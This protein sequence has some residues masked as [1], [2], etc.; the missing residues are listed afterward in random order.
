[1]TNDEIK[2][3][4]TTVVKEVA[5]AEA[6][7]ALKTID[8]EQVK[9]LVNQAVDEK[10]KELEED[11]RTS[12]GWWVKVRNRFEIEILKLSVASITAE[13]EQQIAQL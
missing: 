6:M 13:V 4:I 5:E 1:M 12:S 2:D 3:V 8:A 11:S 10:V 7:A 9:A